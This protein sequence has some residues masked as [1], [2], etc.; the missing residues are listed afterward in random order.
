M[1]F[2]PSFLRSIQPANH[3]LPPS[4][5]LIPSTKTK[6]H[7]LPSIF[8]LVFFTFYLSRPSYPTSSPLAQ[9]HILEPSQISS[10]LSHAKQSQPLPFPCPHSGETREPTLPFLYSLAHKEKNEPHRQPQWPATKCRV[11]QL[12]AIGTRG[13]GSTKVRLILLLRD[14]SVYLCVNQT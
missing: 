6:P 9:Q 2:F 13:Q 8:S 3:L 10:T 11:W 4:N 12:G 7:S 5:K 1:L 14:Q